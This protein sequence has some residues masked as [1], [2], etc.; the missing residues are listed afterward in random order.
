MSHT[1]GRRAG[2]ISIV[3]ICLTIVAVNA[4]PSSP[5]QWGERPEPP[6]L[7]AVRVLEE[8]AQWV[9][10]EGLTDSAEG[11]RETDL[12]GTV[13][14]RR[15]SF[16]LFRTYA[17]VE[18]RQELLGS[19]PYGDLLNRAAERHSVDGLLLAAVMQAES[20]FDAEAVSPQG[21]IGLMQVMPDTADLYRITEPGDPRANV[22]VGA[23]YLAWLLERFDGDLELALAGYNAGPGNV[24]RFGGMPPFRETRS[25]VNRVLGHYVGHHQEVWRASREG[26]LIF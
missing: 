14:L 7:E 8:L 13:R 2:R 3:A 26:D 6:D 10:G 15:R 1:K 12:T 25:Y 23:R 20:G 21:A 16:D 22:E 5:S 9:R 11:L 19:L 18:E 24:D 17:D 4:P